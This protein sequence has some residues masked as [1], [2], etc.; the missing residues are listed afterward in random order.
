MTR[1][2]WTRFESSLNNSKIENP[3]EEMDLSTIETSKLQAMYNEFV[4][5]TQIIQDEKEQKLI[6]NIYSSVEAELEIR[7]NK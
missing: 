5:R 6:D 1:R 4:E 3:D 7:N 2:E